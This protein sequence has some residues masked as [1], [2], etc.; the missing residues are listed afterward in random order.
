[1]GRIAHAR[2]KCIAQVGHLTI[3][4]KA[5]NE[6]KEVN[7]R[8]QEITVG[9]EIS[10]YKGKEM[11]KGETGFKGKARAIERATELMKANINSK[12]ELSK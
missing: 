1:M 7:G 12:N 2:G 8:K 4:Q 5:K 6:V 10:I 3:F 9:T 11:L